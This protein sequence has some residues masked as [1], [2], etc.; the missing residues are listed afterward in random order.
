MAVAT[1]PQTEVL[2]HWTGDMLK[3]LPQVVGERYEVI[4]G[5]LYVTRRPH[6]QHQLVEANILLELGIWSRQTG[7]GR[8]LPEPGLVYA[9]DQAV[10]PDIVWV[11]AKRISTI[12]DQNGHLRE[13]PDLVIEVLS[14]SKA[15]IERDREKKLALYSRQSV[16]EYWIVDWRAETVDIYRHDGE[17]LQLIETLHPAAT[18]TS[19][20]LPGFSCAVSQFFVVL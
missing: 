11:K 6:S 19:P 18:I 1:E 17:T 12:L 8:A 14:G 9:N 2:T 4:D 16:P 3:L 15:D 20:L 5:D 13:S 7:L 10:A